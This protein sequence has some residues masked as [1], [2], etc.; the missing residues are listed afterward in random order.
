L[1]LDLPARGTSMLIEPARI[2]EVED[3]LAIVDIPAE[4]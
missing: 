3:E 4:Q 1:E 2:T